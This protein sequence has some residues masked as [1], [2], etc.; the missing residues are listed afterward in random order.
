M[1]ESPNLTVK[2]DRVKS[3]RL[4]VF[5]VHGMLDALTSPELE[6]EIF[7]VINEENNRMLINL[8]GLEYIS[9]AG[10]RSLMA[11]SRKIDSMS[12]R[13]VLCSPSNNVFT[14]MK[15]SGFG[16]F[17]EWKDTEEEALETFS[18]PK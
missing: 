7:K 5:R 11:T 10:L 8:E 3:D 18:N 14:T 9:S 16:T 2:V 4:I 6:Q 15:N 17:F 12:G 1:N 13:F